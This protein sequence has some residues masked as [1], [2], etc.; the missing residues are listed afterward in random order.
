MELPFRM[1][2]AAF[3]RATGATFRQGSRITRTSGILTCSV[4]PIWQA[5]QSG[6]KRSRT[7]CQLC[8]LFSL[9]RLRQRQAVLFIFGRVRPAG[10]CRSLQRLRAHLRPL[11][12]SAAR[13]IIISNP[14][15][16]G[17]SRRIGLTN[18]VYLPYPMD[19]E[20]YSPGAGESPARMGGWIAAGLYMS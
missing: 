8:R 4:M 12:F 7:R 20:K 14:H 10:N 3:G 1:N 16:L 19:D 15:T 18:G 17:H 5:P 13:F 6:Q 2:F 11:A 9:S